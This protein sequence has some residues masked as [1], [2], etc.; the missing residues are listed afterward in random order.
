MT[1]P[2]LTELLCEKLINWQLQFFCYLFK[3]WNLHV[4]IQYIAKKLSFAWYSLREPLMSANCLLPW[5]SLLFIL[6]GF[7]MRWCQISVCGLVNVCAYARDMCGCIATYWELRAFFCNV[8]FFHEGF[9]NV[10]SSFL[11]DGQR[12]FYTRRE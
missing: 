5:P 10:S 8:L 1:I 9:A 7:Q 6:C 12:G 4:Y 2:W 3:W 11:I